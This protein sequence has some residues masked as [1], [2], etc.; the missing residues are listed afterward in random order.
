MTDALTRSAI[1]QQIV[2]GQI[3]ALR[4]VNGALWDIENAIRACEKR[5]EFGETFIQLA[6]SVYRQNDK[7]ALIKKEINS[8]LGSPLFE[9]KSYEN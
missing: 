2:A 8:L 4:D 5:D 9:E 7:R 3:D 6:R 1:D